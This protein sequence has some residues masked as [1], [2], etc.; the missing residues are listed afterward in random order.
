MMTTPDLMMNLA[1]DRQNHLIAE[2]THARLVARTRR[3]R[4]ATK[5]A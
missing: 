2:A 1:R 3:A 4:R 5:Q